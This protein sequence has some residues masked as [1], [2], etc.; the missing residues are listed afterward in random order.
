M[1]PNSTNINT[2]SINMANKDSVQ[3][4]YADVR[5]LDV[6]SRV[7]YL[8]IKSLYEKMD[9]VN[10]STNISNKFSPQII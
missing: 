5:Y 2:S 8:R 10:L 1:I 4:I 3:Q 7:A 9:C 6:Q